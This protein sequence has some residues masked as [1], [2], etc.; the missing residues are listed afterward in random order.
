MAILKCKF[1]E[2]TAKTIRLLRRHT[3]EAHP[4]EAN[5]IKESLALVD[6]KLQSLSEVLV[7]ENSSAD[8]ISDNNQSAT[9]VNSSTEND[10]LDSVDQSN[11]DLQK[12]PTGFLENH[13]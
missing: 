7:T 5:E 1:C 4:K 10:H 8:G 11:L 12:L 6:A 2:T 13:R 3:A 9:T